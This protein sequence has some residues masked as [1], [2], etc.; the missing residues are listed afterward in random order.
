MCQ[1]SDNEIEE[2]RC[3]AIVFPF[4][5][6]DECTVNRTGRTL[7]LVNFGSGM[8]KS[9]KV[10]QSHYKPGQAHRV[11]GFQISRQHVKVV[12]LSALRTGHLT[13][14]PGNS[15]YSFL[16]EAESTPGP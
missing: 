5:I 13:P 3:L 8:G 6:N 7:L 12:R 4:F 16:L 10:K 2:R 15:L 9:E 11:P 1:K 14:P